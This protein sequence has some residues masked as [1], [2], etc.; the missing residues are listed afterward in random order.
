L[1]GLLIYLGPLMRGL[2][3]T[4]WRMKRKRQ[5]KAVKANGSLQKPRVS[6]HQRAFFLSYWTEA[7]V[8]K[9]SLLYGIA[10]FLVPRKYLVALDQGWSGWDLEICQSVWA[11]AKIKVGTENHGGQKNLLKVQCALRM[12]RLGLATLC[13][14]LLLASWAVAADLPFTA[15]A[16]G[17]AG[18]IH[19]LA[20]LYQKIHLSRV[21]YHALEIV[22]KGLHLLPVEETGPDSGK[23]VLKQASQLDRPA[24]EL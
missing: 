2:A 17:L 20:I 18:Y 24:V 22:A 4:R 19:A 8:E 1:V 14:Y 12:S 3:R 9:E 23:R 16:V 10:D 6:W 13:G 7:G 21:L 11:R 5:I 15:V